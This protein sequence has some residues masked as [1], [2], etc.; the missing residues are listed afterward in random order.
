MYNVYDPK[1]LLHLDI[2]EKPISEAKNR[3]KEFIGEIIVSQFYGKRKFK[4]FL[5]VISK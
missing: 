2:R 1:D 5:P 4:T 3:Y